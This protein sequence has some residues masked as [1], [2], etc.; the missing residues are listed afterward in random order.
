MYIIQTEFA[1]RKIGS[2][3]YFV[4]IGGDWNKSAE[5]IEINEVAS[6]ILKTLP[7]TIE[8][9][10]LKIIEEFEIDK[11]TAQIDA[12]AFLKDLIDLKIVEFKG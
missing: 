6:L 10:S 8:T 3:E 1:I 5:L 12:E 11:N 7:A 4:P 2:V 9:I